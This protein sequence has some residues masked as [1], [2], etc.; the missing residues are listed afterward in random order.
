[1]KIKCRNCKS[2]KLNKVIYIGKQVVSSIFPKTK[3]KSSKKYS[4]DL[5]ECKKCKLVQLGKSIPLG[6]MYGETYGYRSS[7]SKLMVNHLKRKFLK[8][9]KML[10]LKKNSNILD[11]GSSD[12]TF[13]NFFS[14]EKKGYSCF[15][16]DPSAKKYTKYYNKDVNLI[17][18]YFSAKSVNTRLNSINLKNKKFKL[19]SSFAMFYDIDDPN[20][21]CKDIRSLL[22]KDGIWILEMSYFPMLLSNLTYDQICHEHV[23]YYTLSVFKKIAEKNDLKIIDFSFNIINGGSIEIICAPKSSKI[24][25]KKSK[26]LNQL[27][28]EDKISNDD[29]N[30]FNLR[31]DN[32]KKTTNVLLENISKANNKIIGYGAAT[33][34]NIVLNHCE[35]NAK[36]IPLICDE[37]EEKFGRYTPG[38][39]I[40][41]IPKKKMRKL[42]PDYLLVLI[43]SFKSEVIKQ[44]LSYIKRGG[45][46]IFHLPFLHIVDKENYIEHLN[47]NFDAFSYK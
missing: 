43:W 25:P 19:I 21:F 11:I 22:E 38:S 27:K 18:D 34:G 5:Y 30:K 37:N 24:K 16:I 3:P 7:L 45:K 42:N 6:N 33:K 10:S 8:L 14:N 41:I 28:I 9:K 44:E 29:Y 32:I 35:L 17:V 46:L 31:V 2:Q 23:T 15:G 39:N 1:M 36:K 26:I 47:E 13:L 4:L 20:S 12:S 40:K